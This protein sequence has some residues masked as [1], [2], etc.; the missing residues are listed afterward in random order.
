M[1]RK[2]IIKNFNLLVFSHVD[3]LQ[4]EIAKS[5]VADAHL[6]STEGTCS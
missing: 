2:Q 6:I 3:M 1:T 5:K 4:K